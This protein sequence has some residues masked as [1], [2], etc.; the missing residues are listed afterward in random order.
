MKHHFLSAALLF[1]IMN[2]GAFCQDDM[3]RHPEELLRNYPDSVVMIITKVRTLPDGIVR[4]WMETDD[5]KIKFETFC[6]CLD[7]PLKRKGERVIVLKKDIF[8]TQKNKR[9]GKNN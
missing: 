7:N 8:I 1:V 4:Y 6:E 5:G 3:W 9:N 2:S